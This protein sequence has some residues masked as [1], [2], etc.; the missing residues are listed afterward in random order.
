MADVN[1]ML[2]NNYTQKT[3]FRVVFNLKKR[4]S[5]DSVTAAYKELMRFYHPDKHDTIHKTRYQV[6]AQFINHKRLQALEWLKGEVIP[7]NPPGE[8]VHF[9]YLSSA[10]VPFQPAAEEDDGVD[11]DSDEDDED[12]DDFVEM[13]DAADTQGVKYHPDSVDESDN[14]GNGNESSN[15]NAT[16][17]PNVM[18]TTT[19]N[20]N[21]TDNGGMCVCAATTRPTF[22]YASERRTCFQAVSGAPSVLCRF[23][24]PLRTRRVWCS[25]SRRCTSG[26]AP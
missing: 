14:E 16:V 21:T 20:T 2:S 13:E 3:P 25:M 8:E 23:R 17:L 18:T 11:E 4:F 6:F 5:A 24:Y 9:E 1:Y 22:T 19:T 15:N 12:T 26:A 7:D 10:V